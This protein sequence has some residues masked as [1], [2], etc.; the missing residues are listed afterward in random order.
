MGKL[1]KG[2]KVTSVYVPE[3]CLQGDKFPAHVTWDKTERIEVIVNYSAP[4]KIK[5]VYNVPKEGIKQFKDNKVIIKKFDVNG[6]IGFVFNSSIIDQVKKVYQRRIKVNCTNC[7]Y[8]MP[9]PQGVDIPENFWAYNHASMF[10]DEKKAKFWLSNVVTEID[11]RSNIFVRYIE[12][13][14]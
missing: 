14:G 2:L 9:C 10:D 4:L 3:T 12:L 5:H 7:R 1:M 6:Y 8:C 13:R 11:F